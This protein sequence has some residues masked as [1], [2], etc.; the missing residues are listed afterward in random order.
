MD[1]PLAS[2]GRQYVP[3]LGA[4]MP[5]VTALVCPLPVVNRPSAG[6]ARPAATFVHCGVVCRQ[7]HSVDPSLQLPP[8][9]CSLLRGSADLRIWLP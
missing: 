8:Q 9:Q 7:N 2:E 1:T 6:A 4:S 3:S 5:A